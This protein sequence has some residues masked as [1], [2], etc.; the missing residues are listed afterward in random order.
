MKAFIVNDLVFGDCAKG[1]TVDFL[2]KKFGAD[3]VIKY[4]GGAQCGHNVHTSDGKHFNFHQLGS[5]SFNRTPTYIGPNFLLNPHALLQ[6]VRDFS[7]VSKLLQPRIFID[8]E[9]VI[10]TPYHVNANQIKENLRSKK[11]K[12]HGSCGMG[13]GQ[14]KQGILEN[15]FLKFKDCGDKNK[16]KKKLLSIEEFQLKDLGKSKPRASLD[17]NALGLLVD[18]YHSFYTGKIPDIIVTPANWNQKFFFEGKNIIFEGS[19]GFLLD[20]RYGTAPYNT[21]SDLTYNIALDMLDGFQGEVV[22]LGLIRSYFCRH[23]VGPFP[24]ET[25]DSTFINPTEDNKD[26]KFQK[27]FRTGYLDLMLLKYAVK[28]C[29]PQKLA[30]SHLDC[31]RP[32]DFV[33]VCV[34]YEGISELKDQFGLTQQVFDAKP[35][36]KNFP[37]KSIVSFLEH[38]LKIPMYLGSKGNTSEDRTIFLP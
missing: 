31:L 3:L 14:T 2:D 26:N 6:E 22:K 27:Y 21:W 17:R 16:I 8:E 4:T 9:C 18:F 24:T 30:I 23:G 10:T 32:N 19:Q 20:E 15:V 35:I 11:N 36:Y 28:Y 33:P 34:G 25:F 29:K 12:E 5:G 1:A 13:I 38:T 37:A 7:K